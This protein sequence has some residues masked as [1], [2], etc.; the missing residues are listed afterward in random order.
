MNN[1]IANVI[2]LRNFGL[3]SKKPVLSSDSKL[4]L[5]SV[6]G[7][8]TLINDSKQI[9]RGELI[10]GRYSKL[11]EVNVVPVSISHSGEYQCKDLVNLFVME[12]NAKCQIISPIE[13]VKNEE[14][15]IQKTVNTVITVMLKQIAMENEIEEYTRLS[16]N[17]T[18]FENKMNQKLED[19][20]LELTKL[21]V[22]VKPD[23]DYIIHKKS[24]VSTERQNEEIITKNTGKEKVMVSDSF[25][26]KK[27]LQL[28]T[29]YNDILF[30]TI[31]KYIQEGKEYLFP[32]IYKD[33]LEALR[34]VQELK[35]KLHS[36]EKEDIEWRLEMSQKYDIDLNE[37]RQYQS[38][39][40][41]NDRIPSQEKHVA[42]QKI[43]EKNVDYEP[44]ELENE[45]E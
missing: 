41:G 42:N 36:D 9:S 4:V 26:K 43:E 38:N 21:S 37:L 32:L 19:Y 2:D 16:S 6:N 23:N 34:M 22:I 45:K 31:F 25:V 5:S 20:G 24:M 15:D 44:N 17:I 1:P 27:Q 3:F 28:D 40:Q 30:Q 35:D 11:I 12:L 8:Y 14:K 18:Y 29:E 33:N 7:D 10:S 39:Y 13:I